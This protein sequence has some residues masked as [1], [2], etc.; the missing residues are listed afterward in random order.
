MREYMSEP[1]QPHTFYLIE[2]PRVLRTADGKID[3]QNLYPGPTARRL[4]SFTSADE[5]AKSY[6]TIT[7]INPQFALQSA[8]WF[9]GDIGSAQAG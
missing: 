9:S 3:E 8:I 6:N 5:A 4:R 1:C 2:L 7:K